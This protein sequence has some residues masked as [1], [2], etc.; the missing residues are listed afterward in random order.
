MRADLHP[1]GGADP[2]RRLHIAPHSEAHETPPADWRFAPVELSGGEQQ[3]TAI[4][5]AIGK[6]PALLLADEPIGTLDSQNG[7]AILDLLTQLNQ[8][9]QT[10]LLVTHNP[11]LAR[12]ATRLLTLKDG[13]LSEQPRRRQPDRHRTRH[14]AGDLATRRVSTLSDSTRRNP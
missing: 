13:R 4:A 12:N 2:D 1:I 10:I 11:D 3:R 6:S 5:R 9:G 14:G 7:Q 8:A